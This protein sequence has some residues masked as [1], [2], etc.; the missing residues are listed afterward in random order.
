MTNQLLEACYATADP[1]KRK[2][3]YHNL[4]Q[5]LAEEAIMLGVITK[6][7]VIFMKK[8]VKGYTWRDL[9]QTYDT[10]YWQK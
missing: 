5:H 3:A 6:P 4:F 9:N 7:F 10:V 8:D 1:E 2:R